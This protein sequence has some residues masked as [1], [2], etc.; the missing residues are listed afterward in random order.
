M[1]ALWLTKS[2][3]R[4]FTA[5]STELK[6]WMS[7]DW[8]LY[9]MIDSWLI[10]WM[11]KRLMHDW[12]IHE[13]P[14]PPRH[15]SYSHVSRCDE[16][17]ND[18]MPYYIWVTYDWLHFWL[19][20]WLIVWLIDW[21]SFPQRHWSDSPCSRCDLWIICEWFIRWLARLDDWLNDWLTDWLIHLPHLP[22]W[23]MVCLPCFTMRWMKDDSM[24]YL[25]VDSCMTQWLT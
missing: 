14:I 9:K 7:N 5:S 13:P 22:P 19:I 21:P 18:S 15:R 16:W 2:S 17:T 11:I 6:R 24:H 10:Q 12:L 8:M 1:E 4:W 23:N 25:M 3:T 20:V